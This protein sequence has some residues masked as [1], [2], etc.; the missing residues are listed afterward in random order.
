MEAMRMLVQ[1]ALGIAGTAALYAVRLYGPGIVPRVRA[2]LARSPVEAP[3]DVG[4]PEPLPAA[5]RRAP[6]SGRKRKAPK[7]PA[8]EARGAPMV[9]VDSVNLH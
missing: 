7:L 9:I 4:A 6:A 8:K 5:P 3:V 2:Y 1:G